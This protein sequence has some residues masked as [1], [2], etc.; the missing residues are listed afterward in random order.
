MSRILYFIVVVLIL[1]LS[2]CRG[3]ASDTSASKDIDTTKDQDTTDE[4]SE[5]SPDWIPFERLDIRSMNNYQISQLYGEPEEISSDTIRWGD[6]PYPYQFALRDMYRHTPEVVIYTIYW[7]VDSTR[8]L[9]LFCTEEAPGIYKP[10]EGHQYNYNT[11][12]LEE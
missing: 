12:L 11:Q 9:R 2:G 3:K 6:T 10:V 5:L 7:R 4:Q 1:C 8:Y